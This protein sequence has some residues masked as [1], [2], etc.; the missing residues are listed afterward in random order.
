MKELP[1]LLVRIEHREE[2]ITASLQRVG[3]LPLMQAVFL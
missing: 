3:N 1:F 2:R